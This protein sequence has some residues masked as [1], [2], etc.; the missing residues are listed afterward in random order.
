ML[1]KSV[2]NNW[3]VNNK[4]L[5]VYTRWECLSPLSWVIRPQNELE[6]CELTKKPK[7][8]IKKT[9]NHAFKYN[10]SQKAIFLEIKIS[11]QLL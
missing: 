10:L 8:K 6:Q 7:F 2:C 3:Y 5:V 11:K 1:Y 9:L 4:I